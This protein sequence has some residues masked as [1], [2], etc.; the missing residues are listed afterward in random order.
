MPLPDDADRPG[1]IRN[2]KLC[3]SRRRKRCFGGVLAMRKPRLVRSGCI[4]LD[5]VAHCS[6][7]ETSGWIRP[8]SAARSL[9]EKHRDPFPAGK[10]RVSRRLRSRAR[11]ASCRRLGKSTIVHHRQAWVDVMNLPILHGEIVIRGG[12]RLIHRFGLGRLVQEHVR[13]MH[14]AAVSGLELH[15]CHPSILFGNSWGQ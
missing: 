11:R 7:S 1:G 13:V 9:R 14:N 4:G 12:L 3:T 8:E 10:T 5:G 15:C 6:R 2:S